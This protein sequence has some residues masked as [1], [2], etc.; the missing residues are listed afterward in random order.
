MWKA[1]N[2]IIEYDAKGNKVRITVNLIYS[3]DVTGK[4]ITSKF[5]SA[6]GPNKSANIRDKLLA[7]LK[8]AADDIKQEVLDD[9]DT[10]TGDLATLVNDLNIYVL[11][12]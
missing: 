1:A 4:Y 8:K 3:D 11:T 9:A 7:D 12:F 6:E 10:K 5:I 2:P